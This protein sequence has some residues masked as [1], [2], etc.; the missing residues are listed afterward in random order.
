MTDRGRSADTAYAGRMG[1]PAVRAADP[2]QHDIVVAL[3][4][5]SWG[6][7]TVVAHGVSYDA[8]TLPALIAWLDGAPVGL[9]TYVLGPDDLE[10]VTIDAAVPGAGVGTALLAAA[11]DRAWAAGA[12]R[13]WLITTN[14]NLRALRFYQRRGM[15]LAGLAP[16]AVAASRV[17]KPSI[18]LVGEHGIEIRDELTLELR[19]GWFRR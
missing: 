12:S 7:T 3:L 9:L 1:E 2:S 15:R 18:P 6:G 14:D 19:Q 13:V 8:A 11:A 10:V 5:G 4:T 17:L 16:G